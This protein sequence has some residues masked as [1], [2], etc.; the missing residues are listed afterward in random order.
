MEE[1]IAEAR[2]KAA[3]LENLTPDDEGWKLAFNLL[4]IDL[5]AFEQTFA[6]P[7]RDLAYAE[8]VLQTQVKKFI[9]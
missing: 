7:M 8:E 9:D 3:R 5:H 4:V 1:R 2:E 6:Q